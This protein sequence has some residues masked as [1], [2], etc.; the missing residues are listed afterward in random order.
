VGS[1]LISD[2]N[3][4]SIT[5]TIAGVQGDFAEIGVFRAATFTRLVPIANDQGKTAHGFDSFIGMDEPT[6]RDGVKYPKGRLSVGG[7]ENFRGI[8]RN[9]GF[10]DDEYQL[11]PGYVPDCFTDCSPGLRFS[12]GLID[13]DHYRPTL[14]SIE[15]FW[16]R[17]NPGGVV[18]FDDYFI[19]RD[20]LASPA[21]NEFFS[22]LAMSDYRA[23]ALDNDQLFIQKIG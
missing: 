1:G 4:A 6:G 19:G 12:L 20:E 18:I 22:D 2:S 3:L 7:V 16:P 5:R 10:G 23:L 14:Q 9:A 15:W 11:W 13:L 8:M 17:L 21:V